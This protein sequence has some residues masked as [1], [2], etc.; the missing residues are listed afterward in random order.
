MG[1][2][3]AILGAI[4]IG[5]IALGLAGFFAKTKCPA[6]KTTLQNKPPRCPHCRTTL[7]WN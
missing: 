2:D 7:R 4:A 6:C 3:G 5:L 1:K